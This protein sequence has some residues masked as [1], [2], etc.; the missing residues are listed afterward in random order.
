MKGLASLIKTETRKAD[1]VI[2]KV[3]E[4]VVA[5][6]AE[7]VIQNPVDPNVVV[8]KEL[9]DEDYKNY[10]EAKAAMTAFMITS[11][12]TLF[13]GIRTR[14]RL[15]KLK[16]TISDPVERQKEIDRLKKTHE[17]NNEVIPLKE[18]EFGYLEKAYTA[19]GKLN[20]SVEINPQMMIW[21][22]VIGMIVSRGEMLFDVE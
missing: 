9:T 4:P 1:P 2:E 11:P 15:S 21:S 12:L 8:T 17:A 7:P 20:K 5:K 16:K 6:V 18:D 22:G 10:G 13:N 14:R 19:M 3:V